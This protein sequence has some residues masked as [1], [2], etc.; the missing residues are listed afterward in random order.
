MAD[1]VPP[2][3]QQA[4]QQ[5]IF[6][7]ASQFSAALSPASSGQ[8]FTLQASPAASQPQVQTSTTKHCR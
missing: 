8:A 5:L 1:S 7:T 6:S 3:L 2:Q 4:G